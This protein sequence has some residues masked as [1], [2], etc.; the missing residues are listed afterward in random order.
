M[1]R[2]HNLKFFCWLLLILLLGCVSAWI[3]CDIM[4]LRSLARREKMFSPLVEAAALRHGLDPA[5]VKAVI[6]RESRWQPLAVGAQGEIGMMQ[7]TPG[8]VA[9]WQQMNCKSLPTRA[10]LFQPEMNIEIGTWYLAQAGKH[11]QDYRDKEILQL[12]E[13][14]AGYGRVSKLWK[15]QQADQ[16]VPLEQISFPGTR[17]Y[18]MQILSK[19]ADYEQP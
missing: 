6:W 5:L 4:R 15:P 8:A 12:A 18:I 14:N 10:E 11:W 2:R 9:D 17:D 16:E 1:A 19:K 13:Y 3:T 7:I